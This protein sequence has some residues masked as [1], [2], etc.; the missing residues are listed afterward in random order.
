VNYF[1]PFASSKSSGNVYPDG[2]KPKQ[3]IIGEKK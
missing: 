2:K 1:Y 3:K